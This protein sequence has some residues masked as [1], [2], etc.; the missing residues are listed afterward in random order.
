MKHRRT[1]RAMLTALAGTLALA[2]ALLG[3]AVPASASSPTFTLAVPAN[4]AAGA[5]SSDWTLSLVSGP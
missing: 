3:Q 2:G 5:Y 1:A 4:A